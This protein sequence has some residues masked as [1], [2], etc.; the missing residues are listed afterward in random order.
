MKYLKTMFA[1]ISLIALI[2]T[3]LILLILVLTESFKNDV[4]YSTETITAA[5]TTEP[6][7]TNNN[8]P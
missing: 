2:L 4:T 6:I 8:L 3:T 7:V 5:T 1:K